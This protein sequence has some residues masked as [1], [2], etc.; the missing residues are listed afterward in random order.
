MAIVYLLCTNYSSRMNPTATPATPDPSPAERP[1]STRSRITN[2]AKLLPHVDGRSTW[3]KLL[4]DTLDDLL[5]HC[6]GEDRVSEPE[7]MTARR[8]AALEAELIHLEA[9]FA[10]LRMEGND[11]SSADL[12]LYGRLTGHQRRL[13]E[14]LG[15]E[16]RVRDVTPSLAAYVSSRTA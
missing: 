16:R 4:R 13:F 9:K 14:T 7:R 8:A 1:A 15:M 5:T 10:T 12:D 3:A 11:P 2:G 6:G